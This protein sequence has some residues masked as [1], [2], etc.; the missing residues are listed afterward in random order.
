MTDPL[1]GVTAAEL[2]DRIHR[3]R[4]RTAVRAELIQL[5]AN[6]DYLTDTQLDL[7]EQTIGVLRGAPAPLNRDRAL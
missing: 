7:L 5:A 2:D 1:P 3:A 6:A 4:R